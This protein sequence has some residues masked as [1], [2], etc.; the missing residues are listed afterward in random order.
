LSDLAQFNVKD[1]DAEPDDGSKVSAANIRSLERVRMRRKRTKERK[2]VVVPTRATRIRHFARF[3]EFVARYHAY[4]LPTGQCDA[5]LKEVKRGVSAP[6]EMV[7]RVSGWAKL[8]SRQGITGEHE[9]LLLAVVDPASPR[10]P[11]KNPFVSAQLPHRGVVLGGMYSA[12]RAGRAASGRS[13]YFQAGD[14]HLSTGR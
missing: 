3:W 10:N 2:L 12:R 13:Q 11:R 5:L 7:P 8:G 6:E 4:Q 1:L 14:H 9:Q